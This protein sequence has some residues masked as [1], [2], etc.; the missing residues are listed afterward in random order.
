MLSTRCIALKRGMKERM[1]RMGWE[2]MSAYAG[3][4]RGKINFQKES[5]RYFTRGKNEKEV[6]KC[7]HHPA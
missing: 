2:Y 7:I 3:K 5:C 4:E 1:D 6:T